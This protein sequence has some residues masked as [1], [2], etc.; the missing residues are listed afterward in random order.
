[1]F[2]F[3]GHGQWYDA[4]ASHNTNPTDKEYPCENASTAKRLR[5]VARFKPYWEYLCF[6]ASW[7]LSPI[8][9]ML[10]VRSWGKSLSVKDKMR[11]YFQAQYRKHAC[12]CASSIIVICIFYSLATVVLTST[13][14]RE[15]KIPINEKH[16]E[17]NHQ[18]GPSNHDGWRESL[19]PSDLTGNGKGPLPEGSI[20]PRPPSPSSQHPTKKEPLRMRSYTLTV[21]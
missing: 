15:D 9:Q 10:K 5:L 21:K 7:R 12:K 8:V 16:I 4:F 19:K 17:S 13:K 6:T 14:N 18:Y 1:M 20:P 3:L 11:D 2:I